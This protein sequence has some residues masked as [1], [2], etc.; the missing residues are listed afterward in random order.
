MGTLEFNGRHYL[1]GRASDPRELGWM[2]GAPVPSDKRIT[3]D[4]GTFRDFPNIRWSFSHMR[5]LMPTVNVWRGRSKPSQFDRGEM[6]DE[7]DA[8]SFADVNGV[9][10]RFD[11]AL[12]DTYVDGVLVLHRGKIVYERY[13]GALEPHLPHECQSCTKSYTGTLAAALVHEGVLDESEIISHYLPELRSTAWE[14]ATLRQVM[15]MQ[16]GLAFREG[17]DEHSDIWQYRWAFGRLPRP[18]GYDGPRTS[19]DYL[20]TVRK[21]GVH[22]GF[23]YQSLNTQVLGWVMMRVTGRSFAQ[24]LQERLWAPLGCEEDGYLEVDPGGMPLA[25]GGLSATLRDFARFGELMRCEG[26]W[27]GEQIIPASVV[28]DV[29][30]GGKRAK[31]NSPYSYRSQWWVSNDELGSFEARG[32]HGQRLYVA[33]EAEMV[34]AVFASH[35]VADSASESI[36][37]PQLLMLGRMLRSK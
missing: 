26:Q 3:F 18:T 16:T 24:L 14:D 36:T 15:D 9:I 34:V 17:Y 23:A 35:P 13:F 27:N 28:H 6:L 25:E 21:Q 1:D 11:D 29:R 10:R 20:R 4:D 32:I 31:V 5:E 37:S 7:I 12:I 33:P 2:R 19:C 8:L 22:G 30:R